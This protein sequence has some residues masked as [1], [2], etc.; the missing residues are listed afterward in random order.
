LD[1]EEKKAFVADMK[2]RLL[3]AQAAFVV[4]YQG[5]NVEDI[6]RVRRD[7]KKTGTEFQ[8]I[9]NRL[10]KLAS[11]DTETASLQDQFVGPCALAVTYHDDV[12][13][14]AKVLVDFSKEFKQLN[15]KAGQMS[16]KPIDS[17][18]IKRLAEL[19]GRDELLAQVLSAMQAVPT[20]LVRVLNGVIGNLLNALK[21]IER[22]KSEQTN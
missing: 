5:L 17:G 10:M 3:K 21:A 18:A 8:V 1:R 6:N 19:P 12:V 20:S 2:S 11:Q 9:K 16:G 7:L 15:I 4:D 13:T 22:Q 14:P